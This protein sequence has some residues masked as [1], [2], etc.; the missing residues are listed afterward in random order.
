MRT[1]NVDGKEYVLREDMESE[2][3]K[4]VKSE[5]RV[6]SKDFTLLDECNILGVGS[7]QLSSGYV[8]TK[9]ST[10]YLE[11]VIKCLKAMSMNQEGLETIDI[12]WAEGYPAI[13]GRR[14]DKG[15]MSGF[16]IA[17]RIERD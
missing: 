8:T 17:P 11:R 13:I 1:I 12:A 3:R 7:F 2:L 6:L 9:L 16:I 10:E 14:N 4:G 5:F 15:E